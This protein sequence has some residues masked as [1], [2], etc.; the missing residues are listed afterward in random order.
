MNKFEGEE[1]LYICDYF[2]ERKNR[3]CT[4]RVKHEH[5]HTCNSVPYP[6]SDCIGFDVTGKGCWMVKCIPYKEKEETAKSCETCGNRA[7]DGECASDIGCDLGGFRGWAPSGFQ[8]KLEPK[9]KR[10]AVIAFGDRKPDAAYFSVVQRDIDMKMVSE[11][12]VEGID[13]DRLRADGPKC[14][15]RIVTPGGILVVESEAGW[16]T[17]ALIIDPP[18]KPE[19]VEQWLDR[20]PKAEVYTDSRFRFHHDMCKW[21]NEKPGKER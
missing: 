2:A 14:G 17:E 12:M 16:P 7:E 13:P 18:A 6:C 5:T 4:G 3:A 1:P 19:T 15:D 21:Q 8:E 10:V 20:M 9:T 11:I